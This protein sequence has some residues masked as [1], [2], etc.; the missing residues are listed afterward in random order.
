MSLLKNGKLSI[1]TLK[2]YKRIINGYLIPTFGHMKIEQITTIFIR[3]WLYTFSKRSKTITNILIPLRTMLKRAVK[4]GL[5]LENPIDKVDVTDIINDVGLAKEDKIDPFSHEEKDIIINAAQGQFRNLIQFGF[6]SGLRTGELIA[7]RW[8]DIDFDKK[9]I[10]ISR[11]MVHGEEKAPK[12]KSGI[13]SIL[14]LP[15]AEEALRDQLKY[16]G[17]KHDFVFHNSNTNKHWSCSGKIGD[18]WRCLLRRIDIKYRNC[19]QMRHTY[20]STLLSNGE[21]PEWIKTQMGHA[22]LEMLFRV[23]GKWIP[24]NSLLGGY[25]LKGEY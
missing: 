17:K 18:T 6:W 19:Y 4:D 10:K 15:K 12:T 21:N 16:T 8:M 14:M 2:D 9:I 25:K 1:S 7:L 20:A 3:K 13:R 22:T 23:Y 5:M 24:N 11:N